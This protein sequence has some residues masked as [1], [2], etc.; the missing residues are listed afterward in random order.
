MPVDAP[1]ADARPA[2]GPVAL[3]GDR[4]PTDA[5][6]LMEQV[7]T[8]GD[9]SNLTPEQRARYYVEVCRSVGF[10]PLTKPFDYIKLDGKLVLYPTRGAAD[11]LRA[12]NRIDVRVTNRETT[13]G[14]HVVTVEARTP[15]GRTD[16]DIGAVHVGG[17]GGV[18]LANALMKATTKAKRRV[19][20]SIA[21][22][23][24]PDETEVET[25]PDARYVSVDPHSGEILDSLP[26]IGNHPLPEQVDRDRSA[27]APAGPTEAAPD[28]P[29]VRTWSEF[30][31]W[32]RSIG[33]NGIADVTALIGQPTAGI[34]PAHLRDLVLGAMRSGR[35]PAKAPVTEAPR[36]GAKPGGMTDAQ[37]AKLH[38]AAND[39]GLDHAAVK[40][41]AFAHYGA[42]SLWDLS[43]ADAST[44]IDDVEGGNADELRAITA[45]LLAEQ[46]QETN[47]DALRTV[48]RAVAAALVP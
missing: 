11:Q 8:A 6:A 30:W 29:P 28:A 46:R 27:A 9:L 35:E 25:I 18:A 20:L 39:K 12:L 7:I 36:S 16:T 45:Q 22:L 3:Y 10:N 15:D 17:L 5:G 37:N 4:T 34:E 32:A 42:A 33:L 23:N 26:E 40:A 41:L 31:R 19:A 47:A 44:L 43:V 13:N 48:D 21:G 24:M 38:A 14:V 2:A 1:A